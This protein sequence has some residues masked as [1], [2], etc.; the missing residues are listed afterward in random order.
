MA[1]VNHQSQVVDLAFLRAWAWLCEA[2]NDGDS[3]NQTKALGELVVIA[4]V[5][6]HGCRSPISL[7]TSADW[8]AL[9]D[10][11]WGMVRSMNRRYF[12]NASLGSQVG[13][14]DGRIW[15]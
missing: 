3:S 14:Y 13:I 6:H 12:R 7:W 10:E 11:L 9:Y 8:V 2:L 1:S 5:M 15:R 4:Y